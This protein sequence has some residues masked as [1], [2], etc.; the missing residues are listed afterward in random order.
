M[1]RVES[2]YAVTRY[3]K[4]NP[5]S[6]MKRAARVENYRGFVFASLAADGP[7]FFFQAED[8]IRDRDVTGVQTCALPIS[9]GC[10]FFAPAHL[11]ASVESICRSEAAPFRPPWRGYRGNSW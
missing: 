3:G 4:D 11:L 9:A 7:I 5:D 8:G 10:R 2:G 1:P 6:S